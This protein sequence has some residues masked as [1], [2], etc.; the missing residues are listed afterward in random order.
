[1]PCSRRRGFPDG[2][3]RGGA[4]PG[5]QKNP[6]E[7]GASRK[8]RHDSH[9]KFAELLGCSVRAGEEETSRD[10]GEGEEGAMGRACEKAA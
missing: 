9:G 5:A 7:D 4:P 3:S 6:T 2:S 8:G 1:M 10:E